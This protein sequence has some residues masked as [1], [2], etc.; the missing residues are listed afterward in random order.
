MTLSERQRL[1]TYYKCIVVFFSSAR[2]FYRKERLILFSNDVLINRYDKKLDELGVEKIV[3]PRT[4][5]HYS[6]DREIVNRFPGCLFT[7]DVIDYI[8]KTNLLENNGSVCLFDSDCLFVNRIAFLDTPELQAEFLSGVRLDYP[9]N[10]LVNGQ[11]RASLSQILSLSSTDELDNKLI[12]YYGGEYFAY[13]SS[14]SRYLS[15]AIS[16]YFMTIK[17]FADV[18]G[19]T[20][21]EEHVLSFVMNSNREKIVTGGNVIKRVWTADN[22]HN[23]DGTEQNYSVMHLPAEK[24]RF[25]KQLFVFLEKDILYLSKL[26]DEEYKRIVFKPIESCRNPSPIRKIRAGAKRLA[27]HCLR[28]GG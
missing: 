21:T 24:G 11:S 4:Y 13:S 15:D 25:F 9:A 19:N 12:D 14:I 28:L 1:E 22:Y 16:K 2:R 27:K 23:L 5:I 8:S 10:H 6:S 18:Y 7:L 17:R 3:I 26:P 20:Y